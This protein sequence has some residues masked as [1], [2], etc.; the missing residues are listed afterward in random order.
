[1]ILSGRW[2]MTWRS[3]CSE[4]LS[5]TKTHSFWFLKEIQCGFSYTLFKKSSGVVMYG[6]LPVD[7][8]AGTGESKVLESGPFFVTSQIVEL[9]ACGGGHFLFYVRSG[10]QVFAMGR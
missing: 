4:I 9:I 2:K 10:G 6:G 7:F 5:S 1:M 8:P 3:H